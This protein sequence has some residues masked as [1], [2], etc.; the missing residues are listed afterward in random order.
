[1][2]LTKLSKSFFWGGQGPGVHYH[3]IR[4]E[5]QLLFLSL[6]WVMK[7]GWN[8]VIVFIWNIGQ[9]SRLNRKTNHLS[10]SDNPQISVLIHTY[11]HSHN[12]HRHSSTQY[13]HTNSLS[14]TH[15]VSLF[16]SFS[17]SQ[18]HTHTHTLSLS[19]THTHTLSLFLSLSQTHKHTYYSS[20]LFVFSYCQLQRWQ[21][22]ERWIR[23]K[24]D[25]PFFRNVI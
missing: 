4:K 16:L 12:T 19:Q 11:T 24:N 13:K 9:K 7:L 20:F 18:T 8:Q 6:A 1:M 10:K 17:L 14:N 15:I 5:K 21:N 3:H 25:V 23:E 2:I 22:L